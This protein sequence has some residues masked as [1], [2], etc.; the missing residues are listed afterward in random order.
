[1]RE[2]ARLGHHTGADAVAAG[3]PETAGGA[4]TRTDRVMNGQRVLARF[5]ELRSNAVVVQ[6]SRG[7]GVHVESIVARQ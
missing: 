7:G 2:R 5:A 1:M 4:P 3:C 6:V